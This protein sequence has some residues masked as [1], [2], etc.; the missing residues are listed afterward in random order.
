MRPRQVLHHF[1][2]RLNIWVPA[3]IHVLKPDAQRDY[4]GRWAFGGD[5]VPRVEQGYREKAAG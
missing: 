3:K 2:C 4:C 1:Y 5:E